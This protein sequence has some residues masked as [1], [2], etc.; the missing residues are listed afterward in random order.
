[1]KSLGKSITILESDETTMFDTH[2]IL[3]F[4][5]IFFTIT[6]INVLLP[7]ISLHQKTT[8]YILVL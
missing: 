6:P 5:I 2:M 7:K 3:Y 8:H 4:V 1:M